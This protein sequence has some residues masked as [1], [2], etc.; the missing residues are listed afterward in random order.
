MGH[1]MQMPRTPAIFEKE[2]WRL[3][4][5]EPDVPAME[6]AQNYKTAKERQALLEEKIADDL[7]SRKL[8]MMTYSEA[9]RTYGDRLHIGAMGLVEEGKDKFRLIHDGTHYTLV[10]NKIRVRDQQRSPMI[11]DISAELHEQEESGLTYVAVTWDYQNA[12]RIIDVAEVDWGLQACATNKTTIKKLDPEAEIFL[13]TVG[14]FGTSPIGYWWGR[15]GAMIFRGIHYILGYSFQGWILLFADDGKATFEASIFKLAFLVLFA[16]VEA[17]KVPVKWAKVKGGWEFQWI[18]YW[19]EVSNHRVGVSQNRITW[20]NGWIEA[21]LDGQVPAADFDSGLGRLSFICGAL[22]Y[23]RPFL[24]PLYSLA[25]AVR[26][27]TGRKVDT[28]NLPPYIK[29]ILLHLRERFCKRKTIHCLRGRPS[30][31]ESQ[32]RFRSDAKAEGDLVTVGGY[33]TF[34][35]RGYPIAKKK[36]KWF[37]IKLTRS[38]A[39]WAFCKGEPFRTIAALE[40]LGSLLGI[41]LL[42]GEKGD[43]HYCCGGS[44]SVGGFT[45]NSGNRF[46]LA[47]LLT[48]KWPLLAFLSEM[49]AQLEE[50]KILFEMSWVPREQNTEADAITNE[51]IEWLDPGR[52]VAADMKTLP[53]LILPEMLA[54]GEAFYAGRENVNAG[55]PEVAEKDVRTLRVRDPWD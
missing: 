3:D 1:K 5:E 15:L 22:A 53:F 40:M 29:F 46:I 16:F 7:K 47:R 50:K 26:S 44:L 12:H 31:N 37:L 49:A 27:K 23:D 10:N 14:K 18:G 52:R 20:M 55:A 25:A 6:W 34:D 24:A 30:P 28:T 9:K 19:I 11:Q 35:S 33:E 2:K 45:D 41:M 36:A 48:T 42:L 43:E 13:N 54:K 32:E 51:D 39:P 4:Y 8:V 17:M 21:V 38:N